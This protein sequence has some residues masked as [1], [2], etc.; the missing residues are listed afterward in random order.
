MRLPVSMSAVAMMVRLPPSSIFRA[1]PKNRFGFCSAFASTPP[2]RILP[3]WGITVLWARARRV[4]ESSR[5]ITS[6]PTSTIRRARCSTISATWTCRSAG[7]SNVEEIT[8]A[9]TPRFISVTSSGRSSM[10]RIIRY[11]SGWFRVT[12]LAIFCRRIVLPV[13]GCA[14]I[15]P[16][17]PL[18]MGATRSIMRVESSLEVVSMTR[19]SVGNSGVRSSKWG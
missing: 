17:W 1:A 14:G 13:L 10:S 18:P 19:C 7:S 4:M 8:S 9:S 16:R 15:R 11:T 2:D 5:I 12:A 6:L 3:L